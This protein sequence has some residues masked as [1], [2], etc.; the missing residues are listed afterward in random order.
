M[1]ELVRRLVGSMVSTHER[2]SHPA[3]AGSNSSVEFWNPSEVHDRHFA[4]SSC[5][6]RFLMD[7]SSA[8]TVA[9]I[10][11]LIAAP[12]ASSP[13]SNVPSMFR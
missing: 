13:A 9:I 4:A 3:R 5:L 8:L 7:I 2:A 6:Y 1:R 11:S 10:L 12:A